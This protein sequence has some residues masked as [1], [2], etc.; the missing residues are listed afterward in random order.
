MRGL[1]LFVVALLLDAACGSDG[2]DQSR[3]VLATNAP[4]PSTPV[5]TTSDADISGDNPSASSFASEVLPVIEERCAACHTDGG[6]GTG[7]LDMGT[8][9]D[10]HQARAGI[11]LALTS[12]A[13]HQRANRPRGLSRPNE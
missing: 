10:I 3:S 2:D 1:L 6:A 12:G 7:H 13:N 11:E 4:S 5:P 9:G 8:V